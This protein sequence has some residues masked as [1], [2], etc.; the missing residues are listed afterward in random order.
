M[1]FTEK[2]I[3]RI[4]INRSEE[5]MFPDLDNN[6]EFCLDVDE[7]LKERA[8]KFLDIPYEDV[9]RN[10]WVDVYGYVDC[11]ERIA[12][13]LYFNIVPCDDDIPQRELEIKL[14][15]LEGKMLYRQFLK[16]PGVA[17]FIDDAER[18]LDANEN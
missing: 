14:F 7:E 11:K 8:C 3:E 17:E 4:D 10:G 13:S 1:T 16:T 12:T 6:C 2:E 15:Y 5:W 9:I 18:E